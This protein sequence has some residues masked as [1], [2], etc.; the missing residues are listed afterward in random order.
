[1][2]RGDILFVRTGVMQD[3]ESWSEQERKEYAASK[4]PE[5]AGMEASLELLEW[6]WDSGF[7]AVAGDA[8]SW[9]VCLL[10]FRSMFFV[11]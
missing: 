7:S 1:M 8:I 2:K 9:E 6:L 10:V 11:A 3:W 5:H 4:E